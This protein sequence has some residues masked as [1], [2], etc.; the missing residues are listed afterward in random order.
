MSSIQPQVLDAGYDYFYQ[1]ICTWFP[2]TTI[3]ICF[4]LGSFLFV[5]SKACMI[6][7]C[8]KF[9]VS[10]TVLMPLQQGIDASTAGYG[11]IYDRARF[12]P[13]SFLTKDGQHHHQLRLAVL[14]V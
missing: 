4:S 8:T 14:D 10:T 11:R 13:D 3:D 1:L 12:L 5:G 6:H 9:D 7:L 2:M